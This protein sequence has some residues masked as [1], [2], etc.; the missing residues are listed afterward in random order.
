MRKHYSP[1]IYSTLVLVTIL[2]ISFALYEN[3]LEL[4]DLGTGLI[5]L[6]GTVVGATLAFRLNEDREHEREH[7]EH[8]AALNSALFIIA[9]QWNA[10]HFLSR[11]IEPYTTPFDR[12]FN[13][14]PSKP[15][16]YKDLTFQFETLD[17]LLESNE[18][19]TLFR[20]SV[21]QESFHQVIASLDVRNEFYVRE[22][23]PEM[24]KLSLSG[25]S[26]T[27]EEAQ[28]LLGER[29]FG[30]ALNCAESF[31]SHIA[32]SMKSLREMHEEL[33]GVAKRLYPNYKFVVFNTDLRV[34]ARPSAG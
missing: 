4:K 28:S 11:E 7:A 24:A 1:I 20:L 3:R 17:F 2:F 13:F 23:Q 27:L 31:H 18:V 16:P 30:T 9:R 8:R 21:E 29:L 22:L 33:W 14:P 6:L 26:V 5:A 10:I 12:A 19:N 34:A 15:P 32:V 25:K